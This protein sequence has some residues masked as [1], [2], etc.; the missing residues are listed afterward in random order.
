VYDARA[1][2]L[3][4]AWKEGGRRNLAREAAQLVLEVVPRPDVDL[5]THVPGDTDRVRERGAVPPR[6]LARALAVAWE[7][8][9]LDRLRRARALPRQRGLGLVERRRNVRGSVVALG[10]VPRAVCL[11]D[12]VY[13]SGA[14]ADACASALRRAG[15]RH[16]EIV[17]FARAVR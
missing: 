6:A 15:A 17:T 2:K 10:E 1:R 14:T 8:P 12:D 9:S 11:V 4:Q 13:T 7:V 3:V 16:V 5:V